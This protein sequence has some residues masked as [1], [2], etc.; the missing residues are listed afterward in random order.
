MSLEA[1]AYVRTD[2]R[3]QHDPRHQGGCRPSAAAIR[4]S[5]PLAFGGNGPLFACGMAAVLGIGRVIVPP[6]RGFFRPSASLCR[7][8]AP[9]SRTFRRLLRQADLG[10]IERAVAS[11]RGRQPQ[12]AEEAFAGTPRPAAA[13]GG[14]GT[15]GGRA[16]ISLCRSPMPDRHSDGRASGGGLRREHEKT[17]GHRGGCGRAGRAGVDPGRR[18]RACARAPPCPIA[19]NRA[20]PSP[21]RSAAPVYFGGEHGWIETPVLP[22]SDLAKRRAGRS[23]SRSTMHLRG[24]RPG[25]PPSWTGPVALSSPSMPDETD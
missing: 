11:W 14:A 8:R 9:Y 10:E 4:A 21:S 12:L 25:P 22:R 5:R 20:G 17:Y 16:S 15:T 24:C 18:A 3:L 6:A 13:V 7:R 1:A 23:S 19:S 2:C